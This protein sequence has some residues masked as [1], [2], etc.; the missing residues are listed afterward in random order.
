MAYPPDVFH[1]REHCFHYVAI[2]GCMELIKLTG[3]RGGSGF[4]GVAIAVIVN[5]LG[6]KFST[7]SV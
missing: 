6:T 7:V 3:S 2:A 1:G 4:V 5:M